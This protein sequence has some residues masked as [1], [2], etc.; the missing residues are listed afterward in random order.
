MSIIDVEMIGKDEINVIKTIL[1]DSPCKRFCLD[2]EKTGK[3]V[4]SSQLSELVSINTKHSGFDITVT[5]LNAVLS[6]NVSHDVNLSDDDN[7][8]TFS[9]CSGSPENIEASLA[10][11]KL[12]LCGDEITLL[13]AVKKLRSTLEGAKLYCPKTFANENVD[14][15]NG[16]LGVGLFTSATRFLLNQVCAYMIA[17][18]TESAPGQKT[19][20]TASKIKRLFRSSFRRYQLNPCDKLR[21]QELSTKISD[22]AKE[23]EPGEEV[24]CLWNEEIA[25]S[26]KA[27]V[28]SQFQHICK[29]NKCAEFQGKWLKVSV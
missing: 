13:E 18:K 11:Y 7:A 25:S 24:E 5:L 28:S 15:I 27:L 17:W 19:S 9:S 4:I 29:T 8:K 21:Y 14:V 1:M 6:S 20:I 2:V 12:Q 3:Q 10:K 26:F 23:L 16:L 22:S